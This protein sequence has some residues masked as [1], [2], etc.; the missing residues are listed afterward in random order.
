MPQRL[1]VQSTEQNGEYGE[2]GDMPMW[3]DMQEMIGTA[4]NSK[5][6]ASLR[7]IGNYRRPPGT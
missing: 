4:I 6:T 2:F 3:N 5:Q 1:V 7:L